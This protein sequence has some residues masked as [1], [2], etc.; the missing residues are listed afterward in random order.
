M[1]GVGLDF[2][3]NGTEIL[4]AHEGL[5]PVA[6]KAETAGKI[7]AVG[8]LE[9]YFFEFLQSG[10]IKDF[11]VAMFAFGTAEHGVDFCKGYAPALFGDGLGQV[12]FTF[13]AEPTVALRGNKEFHVFCLSTLDDGGIAI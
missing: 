11:D 5:G 13:G 8:D 6:P 2:I 12:L 1:I 4:Q 7:A 10:S 3:E 9:V